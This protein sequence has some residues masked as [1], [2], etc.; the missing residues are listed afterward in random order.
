MTPIHQ[1]S[2]VFSPTG[3]GTSIAIRP[4]DRRDAAAI[5][6]LFA[7]LSPESRRRRYLGPKHELSSNELTYLTD[8]DHVEHE[9]L[10]AIDPRDGSIVGVARYAEWDGRPG[11]ADVA[12]EVAD[13]L[14]GAGIGTVLTSRL[15]DRAEENGIA[16][17]TAVTLWENG[18]A[19]ALLRRA[20]FH[21]VGSHGGEI[22]Y[23][24]TVEMRRAV[25][26]HPS[27]DDGDVR[28]DLPCDLPCCASR[29]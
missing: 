5:A 11:V 27:V 10:A 22:D 1:T 12:V 24:L 21:P 19:R 23:E 20:G 9:A 29:R 13:E 7:R 16:A 26:G 3:D 8:I 2:D 25:G 14:H 28:S 6:D 4:L 15:I 17:L 18:P